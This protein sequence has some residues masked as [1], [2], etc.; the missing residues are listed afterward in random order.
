MYISYDSIKL[1]LRDLV[2]HSNHSLNQKHRDITQ[3]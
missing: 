3:G 2:V 1:H